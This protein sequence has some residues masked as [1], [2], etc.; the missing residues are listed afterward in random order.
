VLVGWKCSEALRSRA[1]EAS[2]AR[3]YY[4]PNVRLN[5]T[6]MSTLAEAISRILTEV[7]YET[8]IG[9][10]MDPSEVWVRPRS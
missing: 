5:V 8:G 10:D 3:D 4:N 9:F 2:S 7:G 1:V 6:A